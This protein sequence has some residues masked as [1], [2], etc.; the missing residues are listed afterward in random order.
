M[1]PVLCILVVFLSEEL[2]IIK[3]ESLRSVCNIIMVLAI[4]SLHNRVSNR[5]FKVECSIEIGDDHF[6]ITKKRKETILFYSEVNEIRL[7]IV[8]NLFG[9]FV[10]GK[11]VEFMV[12]STH[13]KTK[14]I[15]LRFFRGEDVQ[16]H[17]MVK[18]FNII[19][20]V[21]H[22]FIFFSEND[23]KLLILKNPN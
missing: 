2:E 22:N 13:G 16:K 4:A 7:S 15:S 8:D 6:I 14:I 20:K 9:Y 17:S 23:G 1:L 18:A 11:L 19:R 5:L 21:S 12:K 3:A 10:G